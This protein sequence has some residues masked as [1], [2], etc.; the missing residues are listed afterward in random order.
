MV[1]V[2]EEP[3]ASGLTI[4]NRTVPLAPTAGA[5]AGPDT[6][7]EPELLTYTTPA[8]KTSVMDAAVKSPVVDEKL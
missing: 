2:P 1:T 5:V 6:C 4:V 7:V 8:G 3:A